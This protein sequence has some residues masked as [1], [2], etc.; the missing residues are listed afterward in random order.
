MYAVLMLSKA[1]DSVLN[2]AT[3]RSK[4]IQEQELVNRDHVMFGFC[5]IS[6]SL[7]QYLGFFEPHLNNLSY[8]KLLL[9]WSQ[10]TKNEWLMTLQF[11]AK[12]G[13]VPKATLNFK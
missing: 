12:S 8:M 4:F 9:R 1:I 2:T 6:F 5:A 10:M 11:Y 7:G 13:I 3:D